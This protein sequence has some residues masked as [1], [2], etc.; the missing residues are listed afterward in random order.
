MPKITPD[1]DDSAPY[2][3]A[4]SL[5][6]EDAKYWRQEEVHRLNPTGEMNLIPTAHTNEGEANN[7]MMG[8]DLV[9]VKRQSTLRLQR[10]VSYLVGL[11]LATGGLLAVMYLLGAI[12]KFLGVN[13]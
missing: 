6:A 11:A 12:E 4:H 2:D 3:W 9:T 10:V 8:V 13:Q 1:P 7:W 5:P